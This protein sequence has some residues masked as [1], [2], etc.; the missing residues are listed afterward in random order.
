MV[1]GIQFLHD[2]GVIHRDLKPEN[3]LL[4]DNGHIR[5]SDFGLSAVN[6]FEEDTLDRFVGSKGYIA[7]E[8][9]CKT[10][11][12][13]YAIKSSITSHPFFYSIDWS[14]V[15]SGRADPPFPYYYGTL[16]SGQKQDLA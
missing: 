4:D 1:C 9:L 15:E 7:P 5:I 14:D 10:P 12:A 16:E 8:L 13:R 2:H 6:V 3:I 11:V